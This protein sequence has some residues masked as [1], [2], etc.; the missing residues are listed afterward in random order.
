M[1]IINK[2]QLDKNQW[3]RIG[4]QAGWHKTAQ[5]G[6]N[7]IITKDHISDNHDDVGVGNKDV[8]ANPNK[9]AFRMYDDDNELYYEG[10][11]VSGGGED[12][13]NPLD[14]FGMPNAGCTRIDILENGRW[15]TV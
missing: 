5:S 15:E 6:I 14:D 11:L 8:L 13:F 12:L 7:W 4:K 2:I 10:F 9:Q 3:E 1:D